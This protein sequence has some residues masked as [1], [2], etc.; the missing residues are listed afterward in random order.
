[1][2][3]HRELLITYHAVVWVA[4][5]KKVKNCKQCSVVANVILILLNAY[6]KQNH[7]ILLIKC[8]FVE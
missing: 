7:S 3:Q 2:S 1:M 5:R 4:S 8:T 6:I